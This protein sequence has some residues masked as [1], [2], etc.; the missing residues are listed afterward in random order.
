MTEEKNIPAKISDEI[1]NK[2]IIAFLA[3]H[4]LKPNEPGFDNFLNSV[5]KA[6]V[7]TNSSLFDNR[8]AQTLAQIPQT[9]FFRLQHKFI[10]LIPKLECNHLELINLVSVLV[11]KGGDDMAANQPNAALRTW[12]EKHPKRALEVYQDA[13]KGNQLAK[14]HLTFALEGTMDIEAAVDFATQNDISLRREAVSALARIQGSDTQSALAL[15]TLVTL[16]L[17]NSDEQITL[18]ALIG[19]FEILSRHPE[20]SRTS[21][22]EALKARITVQTPNTINACA[23]LLSRQYKNLTSWE[24]ELCLETVRAVQPDH[25]GTISL[26]NRAAFQCVEGDELVELGTTIGEI[27]DGSEGGIRFSQFDDFFYQLNDLGPEVFGKIAV[28]WLLEGG[29]AVRAQLAGRISEIGQEG[30]IFKVDKTLLPKTSE[31]QLFLCKKSIGFLFLAPMTASEIPLCVLKYGDPKIVREVLELI[32]NPLVLSYGGAMRRH[33]K[34]VSEGGHPKADQL[35][36]LLKRKDRIHDDAKD[37]HKLIEFRP[38]EAHRQIERVRWNEEIQRSQKQPENRSILR[39][40]CTVQHLLYGKRSASY[41]PEA[42][43]ELRKFE[44]TMHTHS[45]EAELPLLNVLDPVGLEMALYQMKSEELVK[46]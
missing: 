2:G 45:V 38:S 33:L 36:M 39:D 42:G 16:A 12:F 28:R 6:I 13:Q 44:M 41:I 18:S 7:Q 24:R 17:D 19:G 21:M 32:F 5:S 14:E 46:T 10:I 23:Q 22:E 4:S 15:E 9:A 35:L 20:M 25:L 34:N 27:I 29:P 40:F 31:E 37:A 3:E 30:P 26:I 8:D 11:K 1:K 43:G